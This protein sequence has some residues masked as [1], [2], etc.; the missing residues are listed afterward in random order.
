MQTAKV[1]KRNSSKFSVNLLSKPRLVEGILFNVCQ[2]VLQKR[3]R[4]FGKF[5]S[6]LLPW[7]C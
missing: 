4:G 2:I 6:F 7:L 1:K 5:N 3:K